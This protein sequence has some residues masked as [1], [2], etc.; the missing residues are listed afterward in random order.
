LAAGFDIC[1]VDLGELDRAIERRSHRV[2]IWGTVRSSIVARCGDRDVILHLPY[3]EG[4]DLAGETQLARWWELLPTVQERVTLTRPQVPEHGFRG[5]P[6]AGFGGL[7]SDLLARLERDG[8]AAA[9]DVGAGLFDKGLNPECGLEAPCV[10]H[11]D[12]KNYVGPLG[13]TVPAPQLVEHYRFRRYVAPEYPVA[14]LKVGWGGIVRLSL[15]V[16]SRTG[17]VLEAKVVQRP[18]FPAL[19][20]AAVAAARQ[21]RFAR[22]QASGGNVP[23]TVKFSFSCPQPLREGWAAR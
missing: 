14:A 23:A 10:L 2:E 9:R 11:D 22:H 5:A 20:E 4:V 3:K 17:D 8:E 6:S 16:D 12:V 19:A 1:S 18:P 7:L 13:S 15:T 21:W